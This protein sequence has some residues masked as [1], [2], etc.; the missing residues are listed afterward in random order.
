MIGLAVHN[1]SLDDDPSAAS[2]SALAQPLTLRSGMTLPNRLVKAAMTEGLANRD[3]NPTPM[4]QRLYRRWAAG[5]VG[6]MVTGNVLVDRRYLE[7]SRNVVADAA[8]DEDALRRFAAACEGAP[9]VVQL[10]HA[11]RQTNRMLARRPVSASSTSAVRKLGGFA[12]ARALSTDEVYDVRDRFIASAVRV[13]RAGFRGVQ[14]HAAHG[15][16]LSQ[17]LSPATNQRRDQYG[18]SLD[19]RARL[20]LE[21]AEGIADAVP[22]A[23]IW[24]K[25]NSNDFRRGGFDEAQATAVVRWLDEAGVDVVELSGGTY[26]HVAFLEPDSEKDAYFID[27]ARAIKRDV[28]VPLLLTGG[29]ADAAAMTAAVHDGISLIGLARPLAADPE[30]AGAL[31]D[32]SATSAPRTAPRLP[33]PLADA[34]DVGWYRLQMELYGRGRTGWVGAPSAV[35]AADYV[36]RELITAAIDGPHRRRIVRRLTDGA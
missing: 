10:S 7:R 21:I 1:P 14:L 34:A 35:A 30:L 2:A 12:P 6:S 22:E 9:T 16:L 29:F 11:G 17:F 25:V 20:L 23:S 4:H 28:E 3:G 26:E 32:G 27:F 31:L 33:G 36:L 18:G 19:N 24:V 15:Y 5:G 8:V 13:V